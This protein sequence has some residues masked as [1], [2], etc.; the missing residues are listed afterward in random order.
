MQLWCGV[1]LLE[2]RQRDPPAKP[3]RAEAEKFTHNRK[4][5]MLGTVRG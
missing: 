2:A 4:T 1:S 5:G 3:D